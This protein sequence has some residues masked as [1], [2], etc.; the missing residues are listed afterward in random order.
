MLKLVKCRICS[1]FDLIEVV[2]LKKVPESAQLFL[3]SKKERYNCSIDLTI[4]QC[5][6]CG[7]VQSTNKPVKYYKE[8]ITAA[9]LSEKILSERINVLKDII[10]KQNSKCPKILEIGSHIGLMVDAIQ[11]KIDC[12]ITGIEASKNSVKIAKERKINIVEGYFGENTNALDGRKFDI[13]VC[14]N[15]LEHMPYPK[16]VLEELKKYLNNNSYIY[17]TVP[18][19]NFI[20]STSCVHEFISDHLSYF[21]LNSLEKLFLYCGYEIIK[22]NSFHNKNDLEIIAKFKKEKNLFLNLTQYN[23]LIN[24]IKNILENLKEEDKP[25]FIW[26]AGHRSLTLISQ[27]NYEKI[28]FI[29]DSAKFKQ[30]KF[31]PVSRIKIINPSKLKDYSK[32]TLIINLPGIY[33]EEV[34]SSIEDEIKLNLKIFNIVENNILEIK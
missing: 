16:K 23:K 18:S 12:E 21:T 22:C 28:N 34:I 10:K 24:K 19:L 2:T 33:G 4:K 11:K 17:M 15:F 14:Y 6:S 13:V 9:G 5:Q 25:I 27:L 31:T 20:E 1:S 8:V 26:G 29:I 30:G 7:H 3:K 32:G